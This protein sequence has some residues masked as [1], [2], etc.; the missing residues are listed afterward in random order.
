MKLKNIVLFGFVVAASSLG[1]MNAQNLLASKTVT[2]NDHNVVN[3][4]APPGWNETYGSSATDLMIVKAPVAAGSKLQVCF[5]ARAVTENG[6]S[7][8]IYFGLA[9]HAGD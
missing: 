2:I 8:A 9:M 5:T 6:Q 4:N 3:A 7:E 1:H